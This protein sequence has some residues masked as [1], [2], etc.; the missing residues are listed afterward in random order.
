MISVDGEERW[1]S[2]GVKGD[3]VAEFD[4]DVTDAVEVALVV[5]TMGD[6][7]GDWGLWLEPELS[8]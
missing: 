4:V 8:R 7:G 5:E 1:R 6:A 2:G 3:V